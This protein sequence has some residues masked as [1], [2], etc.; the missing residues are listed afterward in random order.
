MEKK[1]ATLTLL[2]ITFLAVTMIIFASDR[3]SSTGNACAF[4]PGF[5]PGSTG[6]DLGGKIGVGTGST[7]A[8]AEA[9]AI[10]ECEE[11]RNNI[12]GGS[13][14]SYQDEDKEECEQKQV[15]GGHCVLQ[16]GS[17]PN[18]EETNPD[19]HIEFCK[20]DMRENSYDGGEVCYYYY[21]NGEITS[22]ECINDSY[23]PLLNV[24]LCNTEEYSSLMKYTCEF[25]ANPIE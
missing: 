25:V 19:C 9:E 7:Q 18:P 22:Q 4:D 8:E 23:S 21:E 14:S 24:W 11:V 16:L 2:T 6:G 15:S 20:H 13:R 1:A 12:R 3:G 5:P 17:Q 10:A